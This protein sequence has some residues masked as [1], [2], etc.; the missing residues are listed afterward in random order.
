MKSTLVI[1]ANGYFLMVVKV[2]AM[3]ILALPALFILYRKRLITKEEADVVSGFMTKLGITSKFSL[4][5]K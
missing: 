1:Y 3:S 4:I 5:T 2:M